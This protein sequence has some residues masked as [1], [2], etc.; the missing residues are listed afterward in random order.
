M[1]KKLSD[2]CSKFV[3]IQIVLIKGM[4]IAFSVCVLL[5][6]GVWVDCCSCFVTMRVLFRAPHCHH[7]NERSWMMMHGQRSQEF[8][9]TLHPSHS[10]ALAE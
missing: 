1:L 4:I 8:D 5:S 7:C 10:N 9:F 6:V 2:N 3:L